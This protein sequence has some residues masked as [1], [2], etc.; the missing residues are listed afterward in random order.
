MFLAKD[1]EERK[2]MRL[3]ARKKVEREFDRRIVVKAYVD[4]IKSL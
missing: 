4:E 2:Q 3:A 1:Y